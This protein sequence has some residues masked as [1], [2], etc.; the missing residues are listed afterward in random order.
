MKKL[1][2]IILCVFLAVSLFPLSAAAEGT[3][4]FRVI[5][6]Q[7]KPGETVKVEV[8]VENNPGMAATS[9]DF[10]Y[11]TSRLKLT[12][13]APNK[14]DFAGVWT[15]TLLGASWLATD[16]DTTA[17]GT[18]VTLTFEVLENAEAGDAKVEL[19]V[20]EVSTYDFDLVEF[21]SIPGVVTVGSEEP[22]GA[23]LEIYGT[24]IS[25]S[26]AIGMNVYVK[27][28]AEQI[29]DEGF[30]VK[31]NGQAFLL[32]DAYKNNDGLY[33]FSLSLRAKQMGTPVT[34]TAV[35]GEGNAVQLVRELNDY[36][37]ED[38]WTCSIVE[39]VEKTVE[40]G[41]PETEKLVNLVKA[42]STYGNM[43]QTALG[44]TDSPAPKA[45][46]M[47]DVTADM[48]SKYQATATAGEAA[49]VQYV[50]CSVVLDSETDLGIYLEADDGRD[51][52]EFTYTVNGKKATLTETKQGTC[53]MV[54]NISAKNLDRVYTIVVKD[55]GKT[56]LTVKASAM[57]YVYGALTSTAPN[58]TTEIVN[59]AKALYLYS[60][61]ANTYWG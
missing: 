45:Y 57:S 19:V 46:P 60:E 61:A 1:I 40:A 50:G 13:V 8:V 36:I 29:A 44:Y 20:S 6:T 33:R 53:V 41:T 18:I 43:A 28:T 49:G 17:V 26:G 16:G 31:L 12:E 32:K 9:F 59:A 52:T 37:P 24:S 39:Y 47:D 27:P 25:L 11:D 15:T 2:A 4:A 56:V 55:N 51:L 14:T 38:S 35:D 22:A 23:T 42:M 7:A 5:S 30:T 10:Q 58:I 21:E 3:M 48:V 54:S 34:V